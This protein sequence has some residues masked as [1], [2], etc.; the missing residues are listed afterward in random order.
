MVDG[1]L[2]VQVGEPVGVGSR[3]LRAVRGRASRGAHALDA[4]TAP[5]KGAS[6]H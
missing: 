2:V 1:S 5:H 4:D 3:C 6:I